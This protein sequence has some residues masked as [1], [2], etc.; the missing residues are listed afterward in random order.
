MA[1]SRAVTD[2]REYS[3]PGAGGKPHRRGQIIPEVQE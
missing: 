2:L 1:P 3:R